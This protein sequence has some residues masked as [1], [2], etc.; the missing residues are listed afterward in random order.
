MPSSTPRGVTTTEFW[1][2]IA[3][4]ALAL[5]HAVASA[6]GMKFS[7]G[8][9]AQLNIASALPVI[10]G[11]LRTWLKTRVPTVGNE[12]PDLSDDTPPT[13]SSP[14]LGNTT[15]QPALD[16][17]TPPPPAALVSDASAA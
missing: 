6:L 16:Q 10:Y 14:A 11:S 1:L 12:L 7:P 4:I 15:P 9:D 17:S 13:P 2:F 3:G 8:V 5:A